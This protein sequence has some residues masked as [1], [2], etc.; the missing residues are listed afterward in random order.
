VRDQ[1]E[2]LV[3]EM[4]ER[5]ILYDDARREFERRYIARALEAS[6]GSVSAAAERLG[7]HRNTLTRKVAEYKLSRRRAR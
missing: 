5:G 7:V 3:S 1:L 2:K 6:G 4:V